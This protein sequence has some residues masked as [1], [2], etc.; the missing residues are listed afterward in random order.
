MERN[1]TLFRWVKQL[2]WGYNKCTAVI[3]NALGSLFSQTTLEHLRG[4]TPTEW[5]R[6]SVGPGVGASLGNKASNNPEHINQTTI[7]PPKATK[8]RQP[9]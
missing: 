3:I 6:R 4:G 2:E 9:Y 5:D 1:A 7:S 8:L